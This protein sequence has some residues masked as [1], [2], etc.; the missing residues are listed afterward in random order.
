MNKDNSGGIIAFS[1]IVAMILLGA[2]E[3]G[4]LEG[5]KQDILAFLEI[6]K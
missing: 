4:S 2:N 1:I 5:A 6:F 3:N